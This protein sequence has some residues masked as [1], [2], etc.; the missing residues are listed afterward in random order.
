MH[1]YAHLKHY[2]H[3]PKI[4]THPL[5]PQR[6]NQHLPRIRIEQNAN[7]CRHLIRQFIELSSGRDRDKQDHRTFLNSQF[8]NVRGIKPD[9]YRT[10][11]HT[12]RAKT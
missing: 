4:R 3:P 10:S 2:S 9:P 12:S 8:S 11:F 1:S 7:L 6:L 5:I